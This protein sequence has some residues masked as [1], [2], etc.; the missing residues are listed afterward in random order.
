MKRRTLL[1]AAGTL[2]SLGTLGYATRDPVDRLEIRYWLSERAA[3]YDSVAARV[4]EY[5][6]LAFDLAAPSLDLSYGG[7][8]DVSTEDGAAVTRGGEW[9]ARVAAGVAGG[10]VRPASDVNL[11][12]TDGQISTAPTG[13]G[14]PHVASVGGARHVDALDPADP[15]RIVLPYDDPNRA[16]QVLVHEV[17]HALGLRHGHGVAYRRDGAVVATPML[18][19]YAW[20][21]DYERDRSTC[22]DVYPP[23]DGERALS[24]EFSACARRHL[25]RYSGGLTP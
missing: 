20:D 23:L 9:P 25:E 6:R 10:G 11:L 5:L 17:G 15:E 12:V 2:A 22:G 7:V 8:V 3:T 1:G 16:I 24:L 14:V 4:G 18:S 19:A 13:Y 21:P